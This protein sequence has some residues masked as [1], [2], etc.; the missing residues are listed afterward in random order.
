MTTPADIPEVYRRGDLKGTLTPVINAVKSVAEI[1]N[2]AG[3]SAGDWSGLMTWIE[4]L[5]PQF[6]KAAETIERLKGLDWKG[7]QQAPPEG[8]QVDVI[9]AMPNPNKNST[10]PEQQRM[11]LRDEIRAVLAEQD[12]EQV[13]IPEGKG[14]TILT[15]I[16]VYQM[17]LGY[18][19][20]MPAEMTIGEALGLARENKEIALQK[21]GEVLDNL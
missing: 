3:D 4:R 8:G 20:Q 19:A 17:A 10:A 21:I 9:D 7:A 2:T 13:N 12:S 15:P 6:Q 5:L 18:M 1:S 14:G 16:K 11:S